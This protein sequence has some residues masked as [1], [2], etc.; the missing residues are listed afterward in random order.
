MESKQVRGSAAQGLAKARAAIQS[1]RA[2]R[3]KLDK[4]IRDE[5]QALISLRSTLTERVLAG[6]GLSD[7]LTEISEREARIR[8]LRGQLTVAGETIQEMEQAELKARQAQAYEEVEALGD[9]A[10][11]VFEKCRPHFEAL[12]G[13][14]SDLV[15]LYDQAMAL[16]SAF[17]GLQSR[18]EF[19]GRVN[20]RFM[21]YRKV[22]GQITVWAK[23]GLGRGG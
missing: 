12:V 7:L 22:L 13:Y 21:H 18:Q 19:E 1:A 11:A 8:V 6:D 2:D 14:T 4:S 15:T 17:P 10:A 16:R 23:R 3:S 5:E 20:S 9:D